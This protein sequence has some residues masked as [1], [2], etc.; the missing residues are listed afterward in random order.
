MAGDTTRTVPGAPTW[1]GGLESMK[2]GL[3]GGA[4]DCGARE[5]ERAA[6]GLSWVPVDLAWKGGTARTPVISA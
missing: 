2:L 5:W 1:P 6:G 4:E 3:R